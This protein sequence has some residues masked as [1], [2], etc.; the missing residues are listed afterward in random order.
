MDYIKE[1]RIV[2]WSIITILVITPIG[3]VIAGY[4]HLPE[5]NET[6]LDTTSVMSGFGEITLFNTVQG[7]LLSKNIYKDNE[8]GFQ[9]SIPSDSWKIVSMSNDLN[10]ENLQ[11]LKAK[12]FLDGIYLNQN[13]NTRFM[14]A[15]FDISQKSSFELSNYID[16]QIETMNNTFDVDVPIKQVSTSNDWAIFG[17]HTHSEIQ[18]SYGEQLLYLENNRLYMLQYTGLSPS[19]MKTEI[20]SEYRSIIDS[21]EILG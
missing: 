4:L 9:I 11:T 17:A 7:D 14:I 10:D 5:H 12:G 18:D 8:L 19:E 1:L 2:R 13:N 21:F 16:T 20:K 3:I 6:I 15:V